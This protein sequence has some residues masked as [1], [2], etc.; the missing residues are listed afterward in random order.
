M[1][2]EVFTA[3]LSA[4]SRRQLAELTA[5]TD[6]LAVRATAAVAEAV[7]RPLPGQ[8]VTSLA[9]MAAELSELADELAAVQ[10]DRA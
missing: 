4:L 7:T 10:A 8:H 3:S 6:S 5:W 1:P 9:A 2:A